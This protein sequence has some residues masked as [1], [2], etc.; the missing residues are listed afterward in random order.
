LSI[1][2]NHYHDITLKKLQDLNPTL[3]ER[4]ESQ[5]SL[6]LKTRSS[7]ELLAKF[8]LD[9][10]K[11]NNSSNEFRSAPE[12]RKEYEHYKADH[13]HQRDNYQLSKQKGKNT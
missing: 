7:H 9:Q 1:V 13:K 10:Q 11:M 12:K 2:E 4:Y 6:K 8:E 5:R 3:H